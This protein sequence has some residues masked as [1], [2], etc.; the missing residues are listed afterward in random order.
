[1]KQLPP[2]IQTD[3]RYLKFRIHIED[4]PGFSKVVDAVWDVLLDEVGSIE[5]SRAEPWI[6]KNKYDGDNLQGVIRVNREMEDKIRSALLFLDSIGQKDA[7]IEIN[8]TSGA[9]GGL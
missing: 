1:M 3:T 6:I 4:N 9:I 7:F 2:S 8:K 5:L